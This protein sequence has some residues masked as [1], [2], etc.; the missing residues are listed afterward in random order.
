MFLLL[1]LLFAF[2]IKHDEENHSLIT[3]ASGILLLRTLALFKEETY[4]AF[5]LYK[6]VLK[7]ANGISLTELPLFPPN[8]SKLVFYCMN[9]HS[10]P[11]LFFSHKKDSRCSEMSS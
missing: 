4:V 3:N 6:A 11:P 10:F 2:V 1:L 8:F 5:I 9:A 7:I